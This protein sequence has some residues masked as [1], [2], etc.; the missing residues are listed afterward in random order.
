M[1]K[2]NCSKK[3]KTG[4]SL[5]EVMLAVAILLFASTMIMNGFMSTMKYSFSTSVY[6]VSAANNYND[7]TEKFTSLMN[8]NFGAY[9]VLAKDTT[10]SSAQIKLTGSAGATTI[11][12]EI[13]LKQFK[14]DEGADVP[15]TGDY[16]E[17]HGGGDD[18][19]ANNRTTFYYYPS[20]N[21]TG[22]SLG[23]V[24][25]YYNNET[26]E[27]VWVNTDTMKIEKKVS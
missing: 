25:I 24:R 6:A 22:E 16:A 23:K 1:R 19:F 12:K 5:I 26:N 3:T 10:A 8:K 21:G 11:N 9:G 17:Y 14:Y 15:I 13:N 2:I 20:Y 18:T 7:S 4:F 27:Y